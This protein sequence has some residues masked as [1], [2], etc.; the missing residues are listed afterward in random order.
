MVRPLP[1]LLALLVGGLAAFIIYDAFTY[2]TEALDV[3]SGGEA[4]SGRPFILDVAAW[5][6]ARIPNIDWLP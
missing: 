5:I 6:E 2:A 1:V 3:L 4:P